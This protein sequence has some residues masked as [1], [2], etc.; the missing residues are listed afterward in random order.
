MSVHLED[1]PP[2]IRAAVE[3]LLLGHPVT[4][5][6]WIEQKAE[7]LIAAIGPLFL[8]DVQ[9]LS[10]T[11]APGPVI[12]PAEVPMVL[13]V[14]I[15]KLR[16]QIEIDSRQPPSPANLQKLQI[17]LQKYNMLMSALNQTLKS[18]NDSSAS[19]LRNL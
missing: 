17:E 10:Q 3:T 16:D 1:L 6:S 9:R 18:M 13:G 2:L 7:Q 15:D 4:Q 19:M 5:V 14:A 11:N 12:G 8:V